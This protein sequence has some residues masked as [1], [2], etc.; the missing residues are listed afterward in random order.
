MFKVGDHED[1]CVWL[2]A[3]RKLAYSEEPRAAPQAT[4]DRATVSGLGR[5]LRRQSRRAR[6]M[7]SRQLWYVLAAFVGSSSADGILPVV[8]SFAVLRIT[9]SPGKLGIVLACQGIASLMFS[10][11][12][13]VAGDRFP[14]GRILTASTIART[15]M[16]LTLAVTLITGTASFTLLLC[17]AVVYGCADAF[18]TPASRA[19]LP[20]I[21]PRESLGAVNG[22]IGGTA[23][24]GWIVAPAIAGV[25]VGTLGP[26][27]G[28]AFEALVL[29]TATA[30]LAL[31]RLPRARAEAEA[32]T[33]PLSQL[34]SGWHEF[35]KARWL[36]LLTA[37]WTL[38]SLMI[39]APV[40][41]LGPTIAKRY[42]GGAVAWGVISSCLAVGLIAGQLAAGKL[43]PS[44]PALAASRLVPIMVIEALALGLGA[45]IAVIAPAAAVTGVAMGL[46]DVIF[47]TTVQLNIPA[48]VLARVSSIDLI[49]S[50]LGQPIG[51]V[52]AGTLGAAVGVHT[53]LVASAIIVVVGTGAFTLAR[54]LRF[55]TPQATAAE[56][57]RV[58]TDA[59][60][61][62]AAPTSPGGTASQQ[63]RRSES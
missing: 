20:D 27:Y 16:A 42:L 51:Y 30:C 21:V 31:A 28:F 12:A 53:F 19:L 14:H 62:V 26:G 3:T 23:N 57:G 15:G 39:L 54:P 37:Q 7:N 45:P 38:F 56:T 18:F 34:R 24:S 61:S 41:V 36:W 32:P 55:L 59:P 58:A 4:I 9:G 46:Q 2:A 10:V 60:N 43:R 29:A 52:M 47:Q 1:G 17:A 22:L 8:E 44:R 48:E 6:L 35:T 25:I 49:G 50:E 40:A 11:V 5:I 33:H 13:G 63:D